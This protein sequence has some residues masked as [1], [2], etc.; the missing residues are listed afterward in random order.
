MN[1]TTKKK[2]CKELRNLGTFDQVM[3]E[4]PQTDRVQLS[5]ARASGRQHGKLS[6]PLLLARDSVPSMH[7][8]QP[9]W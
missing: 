1:L 7:Q 5:E 9:R 2:S 8:M 3:T 4:R 6:V